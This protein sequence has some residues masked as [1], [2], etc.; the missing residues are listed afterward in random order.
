MI[1]KESKNSY[2]IFLSGSGSVTIGGSILIQNSL[3]QSI[4]LKLSSEPSE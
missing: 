3:F 2:N 1:W 4:V